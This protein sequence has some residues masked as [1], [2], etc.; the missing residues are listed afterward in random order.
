MNCSGLE[1]ALCAVCEGRKPAR[2]FTWHTLWNWAFSRELV[3]EDASGL[4]CF[5]RRYNLMSGH[6]AWYISTFLILLAWCR[7]V[8]LICASSRIGTECWSRGLALLSVSLLLAL[9]GTCLIS[10]VWLPLW[11]AL[12]ASAVVWQHTKRENV[13]FC[14]T[15]IQ[16]SVISV[17]RRFVFNFSAWP[18]I[19]P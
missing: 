12:V 8:H 15:P 18:N 11:E 17:R 16:S 5:N 13:A 4:L 6:A 2:L 9:I 7:S 14:H 1:S 3:K 19:S 10:F